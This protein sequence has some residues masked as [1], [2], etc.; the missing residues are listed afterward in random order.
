MYKR[1]CNTYITI[2]IIIVVVVAVIYRV[3]W[4]YG[5]AAAA[6]KNVRGNYVFFSDQLI[7]ISK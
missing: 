4:Y 3:P 2:I 5:T 6:M 7:F 1:N